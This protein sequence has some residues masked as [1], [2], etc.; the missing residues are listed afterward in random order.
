MM[1]GPLSRGYL[2]ATEYSFHEDQAD[3]ITRV[4]AYHR[5]DYCLSVIWFPPRE[6]DAVRQSIATPFQRT[7]T[8]V[9]ELGSLDRLPTELLHDVLLRLDM[10][11]IF[12]LRQTSLRAREVVDSLTQYQMVALHGLRLFCAL[13]R[14]RFAVHITLDDF[15]DAL[16][17]KT[18]AICGQ[19]G[20]FI[21]LLTWTR[22]CF[23]CLLRAEE[24]RAQTLA[25]AQKELH[26]NKAELGHLRTFRTLPGTY[27]MEENIRRSRIKLV[28]THQV[29]LV[30]GKTH[31]MYFPPPTP[32]GVTVLRPKQICHF[33]ASCALPYY[34][35]RTRKVERGISCSGCQLALEKGIIGSGGS[36]WEPSA[37][38]ARDMV[39]A[40]DNFLE[41]FR[42]CQQAQLLWE[43][44]GEGKHRPSELSE[45]ARRGGYFNRRD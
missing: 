16:S 11:T 12:K 9:A 30:F 14:T 6:H 20:G 21:F 10:Q 25:S 33:M 22:C 42:W 45:G 15:Y 29:K 28:S 39:Y 31:H 3:A 38:L 32:V 41:H 1:D 4:A 23:Q 8:A 2:S 35:R 43:S 36:D 44:S 27:S 34:D 40:Q 37:Y 24:T 5:R 17:T 13:L 19:F 7:P 26:L 18:C